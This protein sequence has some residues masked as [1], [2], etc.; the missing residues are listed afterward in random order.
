M[1]DL[2]HPLITPA[3]LA[4][5]AVIYLRQS[6]P[7]QVKDHDGSAAVQRAQEELA[8]R[9]GFSDV[10]VVDEDLGRSGSTTELRSGF[11]EVCRLVANGWV[12]AVFAINASRL[13]RQVHAF[14][15]LVILCRHHDVVLVIDSRPRDATNPQDVAMLHVEG[16]FA[17]MDNGVRMQG[18]RDARLAKARLGKRVSRLPTGWIAEPDGSVAFDP[19]VYDAIKELPALFWEHGSARATVAALDR[20]GKRL[21][22]RRAHRVFWNRPSVDRLLHFL[23]NPTFAGTYVYGQTESVTNKPKRPDGQHARQRTP[24]ERWITI[25]GYYPAY[26]EAAEQER[27]RERLKRN[28]FRAPGRP[29]RGP[30]L[31]QGALICGKCGAALTVADPRPHKLSHFYQ[32]VAESARHGT[33]PCMSIQGRDLDGAVERAILDALRSPPLTVLTRALTD[34]REA[35]RVHL[36]QI[37]AERARLEYEERRADDRLEAADERNRLVYLR[38][39]LRLEQAIAARAAFERRVAA[40]PRRPPVEGT[41]EELREL[42]RIAA[43]VPA[44]WAHPLVT[45]QERKEIRA[46]LI[47]HVIVRASDEMVEGTIV[48]VSGAR[49]PVR[50]WRRAGLLRLI[51]DRH[52]EGLTAREIQSWLERGDPETGQCWRRTRSAIYQVLRRFGLRPNPAPRWL[53]VDRAAIHRLY[54]RGLTF[55]EMTAQLNAERVLRPSGRAWTENSVWHFLAGGGRRRYLENLHREALDD[56]KRRGLTSRQAAEEFNERRIPRVGRREW[57]TET[58]RQRRF[59]L[60]R[61]KRQ[62]R[63]DDSDAERSRLDD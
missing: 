30:A 21:P 22:V 44:L 20:A 38:L 4:R 34:A 19:E 63:R 57:T 13:A 55:R 35:E 23:L 24:P 40:E 50:V 2:V 39:Q 61:R 60:K 32:C 31:C 42:C 62:L 18:L 26:I 54:E 17:E 7:A 6:S 37:E 5:M 36:A 8:G 43:D 51:R 27:I 56:A 45:N 14:S 41:E 53:P 33:P 11:Q 3:R 49:T 59:A 58:V 15:E 46:S 25:C 48:W 47:E 9:Y 12:G 1:P 16:A 10:R 28:A 52:A 29:G